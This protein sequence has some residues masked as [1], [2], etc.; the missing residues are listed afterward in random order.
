MALLLFL[1]VNQSKEALETRTPLFN[2]PFSLTVISLVAASIGLGS[3]LLSP[4]HINRAKAV[5]GIFCVPGYAS[6]TNTDKLLAG[7]STTVA[8]LIHYQTWIFIV[9]C[10]LLFGLGL[11]YKNIVEK[12]LAAV[13]AVYSILA[14]LVIPDQFAYYPDYGFGMKDLIK[15][16]DPG[17]NAAVLFVPFLLF[18]LICFLINQLID[19]KNSAVAIIFVLTIG[20]GSRVIMGFS[21]TLFGSSFRTFM[22][23]LF[24]LIYCS[25]MLFREIRKKKPFLSHIFLSLCVIIAL[26][27]VYLNSVILAYFKRHGVRYIQY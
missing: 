7:Y 23:L 1:L 10:L 6:W 8:N 5:E 27:M 4:A 26:R 22:Y 24:A 12:F 13:P 17:L 9:F 25:G 20:L 21:A 18:I 2:L 15:F 19:D 16:S 3:V 14:A 11:C